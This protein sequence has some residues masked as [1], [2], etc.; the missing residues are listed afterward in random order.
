LHHL[1][2]WSQKPLVAWDSLDGVRKWLE[3]QRQAKKDAAALEA[4]GTSSPAAVGTAE[5]LEDQW[6]WN[7][8]EDEQAWSK[9]FS[10]MAMRKEEQ[11]FAKAPGGQDTC[12]NPML[13]AWDCANRL[14]A[15]LCTSRGYQQTRLA[16]DAGR[17]FDM[18]QVVFDLD[19]LF[20]MSA[21]C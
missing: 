15:E 19:V 10:F 14:C 13:Q 4:R 6:G 16:S 21:C 18:S 11:G 1:R 12:V 9:R 20:R 5:C 17:P 7:S 8:V 2:A 3:S